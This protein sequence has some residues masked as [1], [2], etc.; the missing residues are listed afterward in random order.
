[1]LSG[2]K[3][4]ESGVTDETVII[5]TD[6]SHNVPALW[7]TLTIISSV[8]NRPIIDF[9]PMI[10]L[11]VWPDYAE[12]YIQGIKDIKLKALEI[13]GETII[14]KAVDLL[15]L[16]VYT[17]SPYS[18]VANISDEEISHLPEGMHEYIQW[19]IKL[20]QDAKPVATK[21]EGGFYFRKKEAT[22]ALMKGNDPSFPIMA[23]IFGEEKTCKVFDLVF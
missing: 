18:L 14:D 12:Q 1:V 13:F 10:D 16:S 2:L 6:A 20:W 3:V 8:M 9:V 23:S 15:S 7:C 4:H 22:R 5:W 17:F 19:Y 21:P 11:V